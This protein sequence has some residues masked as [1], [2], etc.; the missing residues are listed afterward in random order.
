MTLQICVAQLNFVV[1]DMPGNARKIIDAAAKAYA[2]GARLV[3]TPELSI[4]GYAA[5]DLLLRPAFIDA[6]DDALKTVARELAGLKGLHVVVGHP[7]GGGLRTRSVAVTRRHNRASVLCEGQVVAH[8]DKRELP[9]YQVFD[10]R[11]YFTPGEG[12]GVFEV[13]GVRVGLLI[14]EDAWFEEPARLARD[15]GA[16]LLAVLNASPF[17]AGKGAEREQRMRERVVD[18]GLPLIYAHLVG[19]QDEVIFEGRSFA[20]NA[21]GQV[22][23]RAEGFR[24]ACLHVQAR[25]GLSGLDVTA[26]GDALVPLA[27]ADA[28]LWDALVLG[29]RDYLG[30]NGFKQAILG[31]S[32]GIDSALVLAIAVDAIGADKIHAVMMPSPYTAD[33]SWI[34]SRDMV[35][36]LNVRYDEIAISPLFDGFRQALSSQFAGLKEDA[37]EENIQARIRGTLLMAL[38]N[39]TGAIVLTTGNKSEMATGYCT[40]Y[41]DMAGGF[42]VIKDVVKTRVFDLARWRNL[43]DPYGTGSQPIPER[44]ITRP[45]SAELRPDQKDQDSLPEYE[46]LD[47]IIERYMENDEGVEALI[48][49]GFDRADVEKVTRL[50]KLNEYKRRQSPVGIRVTHRSFG[51]DWRY[52]MTNKFRA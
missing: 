26:A 19:G 18:C 44:I 28:E 12:V 33:I 34:D 22:V 17:H 46:V 45:P 32:G 10:E 38:S 52:P 49:D 23:A 40:L 36:R 15:A 20:L 1:G 29:V 5:E 16:Q 2:E 51:K 13:E 7:E 41:G 6:C 14:C 24:E 31:L 3:I 27:T 11:R 35:K 21:L 39:K 37:T 47:A 42:A 9:N 50:I 48:A 30:K 8:Y 4:C 43:N 25:S